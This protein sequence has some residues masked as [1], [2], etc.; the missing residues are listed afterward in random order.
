MKKIDL[1]P[2]HRSDAE[3]VRVE[4]LEELLAGLRRFPNKLRLVRDLI[5]QQLS[6]ENDPTVRAPVKPVRRTA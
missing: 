3:D 5:A 1:E 6:P 2:L 4:A